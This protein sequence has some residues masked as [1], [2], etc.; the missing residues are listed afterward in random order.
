MFY[1]AP[2]TSPMEIPAE[3]PP[4]YTRYDLPEIGNP[5][6]MPALPDIVD[7]GVKGIRLQGT[8]VRALPGIKQAGYMTNVRQREAKEYANDIRAAY[9]HM[10]PA[11]KRSRA[12]ARAKNRQAER[13]AREFGVR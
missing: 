4:S 8:L 7:T 2:V 12:L 10:A 5:N 9:A 1:G 6:A 11:Q 3:L 13:L